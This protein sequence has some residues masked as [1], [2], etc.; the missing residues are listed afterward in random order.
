M[1]S[2]AWETFLKSN[3]FGDPFNAWHDGVE[4]YV[5]DALSQ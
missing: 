1:T 5:L 4:T 3:F 2:P